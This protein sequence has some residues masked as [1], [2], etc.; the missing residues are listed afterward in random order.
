MDGLQCFEKAPDLDGP[1]QQ[2]IAEYHP[3]LKDASIA[4][5]YRT[6]GWKHKD[7]VQ[8]GK[9][10]IASPLW[11]SLSGYDLLV[12][13]N[14]HAYANL[15]EEQKM[16]YLDYVLSYVR[17]PVVSRCGTLSYR[18]RDHDI[19]EFSA[20]INR[21]NVCFSN[22]LAIDGQGERQ[23]NLFGGSLEGKIIEGDELG[24]AIREQD[25]AMQELAAAAAEDEDDLEEMVTVEE[26]DSE[27][28]LEGTVVQSF[29][30]G[31]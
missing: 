1:V 30:I 23:L 11:R 29:D 17:E 18:T 31:S 13:I 16:A 25:A 4:C 10:V 27:E 7:T 21:H 15:D 2:A 8:M 5:V 20:V 26:Y 3:Y 9:V 14:K 28:E 19:R 24:A 6:G 22:M 12:V